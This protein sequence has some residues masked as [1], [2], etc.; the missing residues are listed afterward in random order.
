[1]PPDRYTTM[2]KFLEGSL[3]YGRHVRTRLFD[4]L[5]WLLVTE[6]KYYFPGGRRSRVG[7]MRDKFVSSEITAAERNF[8]SIKSNDEE[9]KEDENEEEIDS[10]E[11][12]EKER[13]EKVFRET[14]AFLRVLLAAFPDFTNTFLL[15]RSRVLIDERYWQILN[16]SIPKIIYRDV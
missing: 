15:M 6:N 12:E 7:Y 14:A 8:A 2:Q 11:A 9:K 3:R 13:K 10:E 5:V 4:Y 1:M 16:P